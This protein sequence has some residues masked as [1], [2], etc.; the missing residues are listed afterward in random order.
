VLRADGGTAG[1]SLGGGVGFGM[2]SRMGVAGA[3]LDA[4]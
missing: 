3:D 4:V 1:A 2:G